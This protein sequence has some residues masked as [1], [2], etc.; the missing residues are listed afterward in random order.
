MKKGSDFYMKRNMDL[1]RDL[2]I[3]IEEQDK[4]SRELKLPPE[5]DRTV[6]VYHL[7]LMEQAGFTT[8]N[9]QY[10][11]NKPLWINSKLTWDGHDFLDS[12]KNDTVWNKTKEAIKSK[13]LEIGQLSFG[14][15]KE[16]VKLKLN[17][18]L[19]IY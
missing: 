8:N 5:M 12:I 18:Q 13:G 2:L 15:L 1:I 4:D 11:D 10:A 6:A 3:L 16:Y 19:G 9:I 7:N 14:V 17:E